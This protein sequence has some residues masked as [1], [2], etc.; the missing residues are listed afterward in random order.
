MII[1]GAIA[2]VVNVLRYLARIG[3]GGF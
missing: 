3:L 2:H 1:F